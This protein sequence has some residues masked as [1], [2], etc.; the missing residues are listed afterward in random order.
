MTFFDTMAPAATMNW[1][2]GVV[3]LV[4]KPKDWTSFDVV[5]KIRGSLKR[6]TG[7]KNLKV[8]HAGTLDPMATGLLILCVGKATKSIDSFMGL[9]KRY[10]GTITFGAT[11]PSFDAETPIDKHYPTDHITGAALDALL[12]DFTGEILQV[13]PMY[14][15]I[16]K[17]G[18]PLYALARKG[19]T[20]ELVPRPVTIHS[21]VITRLNLPEAE[22]D[23]Q[24][25][26]GTYIRS[27][28]YDL[29]KAVNSG[30]YLSALRR[31]AIGS[32]EV[33]NAWTMDTLIPKLSNENP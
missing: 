22:F 4:D 28:A 7:I 29:G 12:P 20:L 24:C 10:T 13:P 33:S 5:A 17:T 27:L 6:L 19:T 32:Y 1:G 21:I 16:K 31:T 23:V 25:S 18:T 2:E 30:A 8:G 15:A 9:E 14:S 26:K 3:I 11:T